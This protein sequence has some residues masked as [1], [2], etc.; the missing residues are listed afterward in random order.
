MLIRVVLSDAATGKEPIL[1]VSSA[2]PARTYSP[3]QKYEAGES[4][5]HPKF[6]RGNVLSAT[7]ESIEVAFA[8][9]IRKL[10]HGL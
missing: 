1:V 3:R 7:K 4:V 9:A 10:V 6:G 2:A 5:E 8:D